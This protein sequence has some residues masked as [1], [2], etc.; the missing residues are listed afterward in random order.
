MTKTLQTLKTNPPGQGCRLPPVLLCHK[1]HKHSINQATY[2]QSTPVQRERKNHGFSG[3][4]SYSAVVAGSKT[5]E[6]PTKQHNTH[7]HEIQDRDRR[8]TVRVNMK[9]Q[10]RLF[11]LIRLFLRKIRVIEATPKKIPELFQV[12]YWHVYTHLWCEFQCNTFQCDCNKTKLRF[13]QVKVS[14]SFLHLLLNSSNFKEVDN[15]TRYTNLPSISNV[16]KNVVIK[17]WSGGLRFFV[18]LSS[19]DVQILS[20][21]IAS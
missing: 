4:K 8:S 17:G 1:D 6:Q 9:N 7:T 18:G 20:E 21:S 16:K 3:S 11:P 19:Q 14:T 15:K 2:V 10:E 12:T 13:W 5:T